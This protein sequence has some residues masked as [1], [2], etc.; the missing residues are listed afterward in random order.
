MGAIY[1]ILFSVVIFG[2]QLFFC[3]GFD[4]FVQQLGY[5]HGLLNPG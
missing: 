1:D 3:H 5:I 2:F 4:I